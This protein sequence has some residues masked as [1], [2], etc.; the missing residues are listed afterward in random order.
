ML[1]LKQIMH[2]YQ[3]ER[4]AVVMGLRIKHFVCSV[5]GA[6][7]SAEAPNAKYCE[8]C[9]RLHRKQRAKLKMACA[10]LQ[11]VL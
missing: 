2:P 6:A 11:S 3:P 10:R 7:A 9:R 5:C 4:P 1:H 8:S